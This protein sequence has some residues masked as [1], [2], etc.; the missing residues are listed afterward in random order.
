[1]TGVTGVTGTTGVTGVTGTT[2]VTG[3]GQTGQTGETGVTG[4]IGPTGAAGSG[5]IIAFSSGAAVSLATVLA[6]VNNSYGFGFTDPSISLLDLL[7]NTFFSVPRAGTVTR[8][9]VTIRVTAGVSVAGTLSFT[10]YRA[11]PGTSSVYT[12]L[13]GVTLT[14]AIPILSLLT[15]FFGDSGPVSV[16]VAVGDQ[17]ALVSSSS[18]IAAAVVGVVGAGLAIS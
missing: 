5:A 12:A 7:P 8:L 3:V 11:S 18:G 1:M 14:V 16:P 6:V 4:L 9:T 13:P 10:I 2:G 15:T 17:L